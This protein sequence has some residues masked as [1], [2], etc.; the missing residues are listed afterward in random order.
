MSVTFHA[1]EALP[2]NEVKE[3]EMEKLSWIFQMGLV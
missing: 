1:K 2:M 3:L